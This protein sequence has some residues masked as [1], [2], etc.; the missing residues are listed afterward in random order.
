MIALEG[1]AA[2][3]GD[4]LGDGSPTVEK[5][6][7]AP[8]YRSI[9]ARSTRM[10]RLHLGQWPI[11]SQPLERI[12]ATVSAVRRQS[13]ALQQ[14]A[15]AAWE[16]WRPSIL[17]WSVRKRLFE[18]RAGVEPAPNEDRVTLCGLSFPLS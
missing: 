1:A 18:F 8:E 3:V 9:R 14:V 2:F 7:M 13:S 11:T 17:G 6:V 10:V 15:M 12:W 4:R 16:S 5:I